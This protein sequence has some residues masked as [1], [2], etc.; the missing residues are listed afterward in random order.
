MYPFDLIYCD[1]KC[2]MARGD[3]PTSK[4]M[5]QLFDLALV[6]MG[7]LASMLVF[8]LFSK[9]ADKFIYASCAFIILY[10]IGMLFIS[11]KNE[12]QRCLGNDLLMYK[13]VR[14]TTMAIIF[15]ATLV[16]LAVFMI[17]K[18]KKPVVVAPVVN[19]A[20]PMNPP[21]MPQQQRPPQMPQ[22]PQ[23]P[24]NGVPQAPQAPPQRPAYNPQGNRGPNNN[25]N[26]R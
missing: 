3:N 11:N 20:P 5:Y 26:F 21:M 22:M 13:I 17:A 7:I 9:S 2:K 18:D 8:Y 25:N 12:F 6:F 4:T 10:G 16:I 15:L 23:R 14:Y 19:N 24:P 1:S